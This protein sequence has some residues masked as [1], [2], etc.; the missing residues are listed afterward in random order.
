MLMCCIP[1]CDVVWCT[2]WVCLYARVLCPVVSCDVVYQ[3]G[4]PLFLLMYRVPGV[5]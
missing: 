4:V 5:M 2:N 3:L 1:W